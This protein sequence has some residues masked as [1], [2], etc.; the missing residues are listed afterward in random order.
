MFYASCCHHRGS[1]GFENI[2]YRQLHPWEVFFLQYF[3]W[4]SSNLSQTNPGYILTIHSQVVKGIQ[5]SVTVHFW[6][7]VDIL[8]SILCLVYFDILVGHWS[9]HHPTPNPHITLRFLFFNSVCSLN[10]LAKFW[11]CIILTFSAYY[12][13]PNIWSLRICHPNLTTAGHGASARLNAIWFSSAFWFSSACKQSSKARAL[14]GSVVI[15]FG[16]H[17]SASI[18][19]FQDPCNMHPGKSALSSITNGS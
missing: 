1:W 4:V 8:K 19:K 6:V 14:S 13:F 7:L 11:I 2:N 15:V 9:E 16:V 18:F 3:S 10:Y 12:L 5:V 17:L